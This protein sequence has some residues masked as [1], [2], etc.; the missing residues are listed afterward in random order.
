MASFVSSFLQFILVLLPVHHTAYL[1]LD[2]NLEAPDS[3]DENRVDW[4]S[5]GEWHGSAHELDYDMVW[6]DEDSG[7]DL[8]ADEGL[9][10]VAVNED[11]GQAHAHEF[12]LNQVPDGD[13]DGID[14]G[15]ANLDAEAEHGDGKLSFIHVYFLLVIL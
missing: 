11:D 9:E 13:H 14:G 12:D 2:L 8:G 1:N 7:A 10:Q 15:A 4:S 6:V 5:I 3:E